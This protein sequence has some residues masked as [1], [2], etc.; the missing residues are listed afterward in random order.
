MRSEACCFGAS[1]IGDGCFVLKMLYFREYYR[2]QSRRLQE[3]ILMLRTISCALTPRILPARRQPLSLTEL[4]TPVG[5]LATIVLFITADLTRLNYRN[6]DR[7][8]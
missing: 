2:K 8:F 4:P 3:T 7:S 1:H 6:G 5:F